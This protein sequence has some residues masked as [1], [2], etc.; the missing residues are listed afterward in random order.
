MNIVQILSNNNIK[1]PN[2]NDKTIYIYIY[3][4]VYM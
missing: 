2:K 3:I 1:N 4:D